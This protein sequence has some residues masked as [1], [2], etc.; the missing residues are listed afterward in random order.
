M[1]RD[2]NPRREN[3]IESPS[4]KGFD[5]QLDCKL[6]HGNKNETQLTL[7]QYIKFSVQKQ[8]RTKQE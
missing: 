6:T 2:E 5:A 3:K 7:V 1:N 4:F 8:N